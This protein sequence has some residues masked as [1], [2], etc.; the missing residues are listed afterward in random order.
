MYFIFQVSDLEFMMSFKQSR[1][2]RTFWNKRVKFDFIV[3]FLNIHV[4]CK[5]MINN[6]SFCY[7]TFVVHS[8][9]WTGCLRKKLSRWGQYSAWNW[10]S[11][12]RKLIILFVYW[13]IKIFSCSLYKYENCKA[14][15]FPS[16]SWISGKT[17]FW[18]I[19]IVNFLCTNNF[20][21]V[22]L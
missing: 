4:S 21:F 11:L 19:W 13:S 1:C 16:W 5:I 14:Y 2:G 10:D 15:T 3:Y 22:H 20:F 9:T 12:R 17:W 18:I 7:N 6:T 8:L